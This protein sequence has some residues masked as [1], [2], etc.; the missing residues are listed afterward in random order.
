[1]RY[2]KREM[3]AL[4]IPAYYLA[5]HYTSAIAHLLAIYRNVVFFSFNFFSIKILFRT[6]FMPF[7]RKNKV[8]KNEEDREHLVV[9]I[10]MS[11]LGFI[12]RTATV[13]CG[14]C[15]MLLVFL[16]WTLML[17]IWMVLP[18]VAIILFIFGMISFFQ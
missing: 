4:L 1:M 16:F 8:A 12:I 13:I 9:T 18:F 6:L 2:N 11:L 17:C 10:M 14:A 7:S 3:K 5:W 15:A